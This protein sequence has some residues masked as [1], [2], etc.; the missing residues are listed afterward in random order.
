LDIVLVG[1]PASVVE[2]VCHDKLETSEVVESGDQQEANATES[3]EQST[4]LRQEIER[5]VNNT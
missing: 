5:A 4:K 1:L 2:V 3:T